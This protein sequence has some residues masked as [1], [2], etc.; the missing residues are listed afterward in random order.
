[1]QND[2]KGAASVLAHELLDAGL[3]FCFGDVF[4]DSDGTADGGDGCQVH[5]DDEVVY[6]DALHRHLHPASG[7]GAE[8]EDG[9]CGLEELELGIELDQLP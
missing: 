8:V 7:G 1:M 6:G 9:A 4:L 5:A 3:A 2:V